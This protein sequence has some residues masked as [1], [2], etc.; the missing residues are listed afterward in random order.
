MDHFFNI[1]ELSF[2]H[3]KRIMKAAQS[4]IM[5]HNSEDSRRT[6]SEWRHLYQLETVALLSDHLGSLSTEEVRPMLQKL[7]EARKLLVEGIMKSIR[8]KMARQ[9]KRLWDRGLLRA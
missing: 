5:L 4:N 9:I 6:L 1:C 7:V 2:Y 3:Y 8:H